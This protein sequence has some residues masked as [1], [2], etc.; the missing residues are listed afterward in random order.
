[1]TGGLQTYV[2]KKGNKSESANY[3]PISLTCIL[4]QQMEHIIASTIMGHLNTTQQLYQRQHGFRP[5]L[6]CET[7]LIE[8]STDVLRALHDNKQCDAIFMDFSKAFDKVSH[9]CLLY[10]L[11]M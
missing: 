10:K 11:N 1:M 3:R 2:Y 6:S 8:F 9:S 5:K 4:S 7:Q